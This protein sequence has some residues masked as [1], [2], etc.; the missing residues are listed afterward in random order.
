MPSGNDDIAAGV[1]VFRSFRI[2]QH[3]E[4]PR[5]VVAFKLSDVATLNV[6]I[7]L[8]KD[9]RLCRQRVENTLNLETSQH[10]DQEAGFEG[11]RKLA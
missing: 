3:L 1:S 2:E 4:A 10:P 6:S 8:K 7:Q 5:G 9:L 11:I